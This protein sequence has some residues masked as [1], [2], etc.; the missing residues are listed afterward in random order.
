MWAAG[1][2]DG[3]LI[4]EFNPDGSENLY[5]DLPR[6]KIVNF[7]LVQGQRSGYFVDLKTGVFHLKDHRLSKA[8][9]IVLPINKDRGVAICGGPGVNYTFHHYKEAHQDFNAIGRNVG[10]TV[11]DRFLLGWSAW[12]IVPTLGQRYVEAT[13]FVENVEAPKPVLKVFLR[14]EPRGK[15]IDGSPYDTSL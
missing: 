1:L 6:D 15:P 10:G 2:E 5:T 12:K 3:S 11:I 13:L 4:T 9:N 8:F 14:A 7:G